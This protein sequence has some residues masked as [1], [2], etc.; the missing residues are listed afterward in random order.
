MSCDV[1]S[2]RLMFHFFSNAFGIRQATWLM[3]SI[4]LM[5]Q[6]WYLDDFADRTAQGS[7][8]ACQQ[9]ACR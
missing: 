5:L 8:L 7:D 3:H 9:D 2:M 1:S 4:A 6:Q